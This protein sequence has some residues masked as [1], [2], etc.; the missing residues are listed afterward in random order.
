MKKKHYI[1]ISIVALV[2]V[3]GASLWLDNRNKAEA[4]KIASDVP[5]PSELFREY[6][7]FATSTTPGPI[8]FAT[9]TNATSTNI[10]RTVHTDG[11]IDNGQL[12]IAGAKKVTFFFSRGDATG[13]GN[14][15]S[16]RF[17]VQVSPDGTNW[18]YFE[19]F[20]N[21]TSSIADASSM[22]AESL[23]IAAATNTLIASMDLGNNTFYSVRCIVVETT[24]GEHSCK[25][26]ATW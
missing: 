20:K 21:A 26:L 19:K 8:G 24:D 6:D 18:Y 2:L 14:T 17:R 11:R 4:G 10:N 15:G 13:Q 25:A 22:M 9:T 7:F 12:V 16:T 1:L 23:S 5:Q 3:S